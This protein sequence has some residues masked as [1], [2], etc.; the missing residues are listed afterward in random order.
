MAW[1]KLPIRLPDSLLF[2]R[3]GNELPDCS[4]KSLNIPG[5]DHVARL[6]VTQEVDLTAV[7]ERHHRNPR[8]HGF[9]VDEA[10]PLVHGR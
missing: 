3:V 4:N 2:C 5:R 9:E 10:E 6:P 8:S 7:V 1:R